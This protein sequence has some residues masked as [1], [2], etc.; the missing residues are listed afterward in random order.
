VRDTHNIFCASH[1]LLKMMILPRQ[2]RDKHRESTQK[3]MCFLAGV[4][5]VDM[6][7]LFATSDFIS[8]NCPLNDETEGIV[9]AARLA[10]MKPSAFLINTR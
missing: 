1:F 8:I 4:R 9:S 2:A 10:Q 6:D 5:L 7:E 3:A